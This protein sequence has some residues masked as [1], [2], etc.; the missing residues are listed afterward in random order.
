MQT[1]AQAAR[2]VQMTVK[3]GSTVVVDTIGCAVNIKGSAAASVLT[4]PSGM[5]TLLIYNSSA[6]QREDLS[7]TADVGSKASADGKSC[8]ESV[9]RQYSLSFMHRPRCRARL[10]RHR[11][12]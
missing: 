7:F 9:N 10:C 1:F 11:F 4:V 12:L 2:E 3:P 8:E 6:D 5:K